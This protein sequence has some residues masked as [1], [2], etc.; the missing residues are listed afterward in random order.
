MWFFPVEDPSGVLNYFFC[1]KFY[2][3]VEMETKRKMEEIE[4]K[5][6]EDE[7]LRAAVA[8]QVL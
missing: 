1:P 8:L 2:R 4:R 5:R 3:K 7:D 6:Q